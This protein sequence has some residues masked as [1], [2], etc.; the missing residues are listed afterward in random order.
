M[1][2]IHIQQWKRRLDTNSFVLISNYFKVLQYFA[3]QV[4]HKESW[5][6]LLP[7]LPP[8]IV[9][10]QLKN[11]GNKVNYI[12][13]IYHRF[14][15]VGFQKT[16]ISTKMENNNHKNQLL[17]NSF[18]MTKMQHL[19]STFKTFSQQECISRDLSSK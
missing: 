10:P 17:Q 13:I 14:I 18:S 19:E 8:V 9:L 1:I 6:M 7:N 16:K 4:L 2:N 3:H 12:N 5:R 15:H 11:K